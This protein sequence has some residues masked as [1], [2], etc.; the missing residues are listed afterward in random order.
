MTGVKLPETG[1]VWM[2]PTILLGTG[3]VAY[4]VY[5]ECKKKQNRQ[6]STS[7]KNDSKKDE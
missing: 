5:E 1:S 6:N 3:C 2:I 7:E 4:V